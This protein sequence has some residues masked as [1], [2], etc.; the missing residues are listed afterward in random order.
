LLPMDVGVVPQ[1]FSL[2]S[3]GRGFA[4]VLE[5][6][7]PFAAADLDPQSLS[8]ALGSGPE[9]PVDP[10]SATLEDED[11][12]GVEELVVHLDRRLLLSEVSGF[13]DFSIVV[14]GA[15]RSGTQARGTA[16]LR[17]LA[18]PAR[19]QAQEPTP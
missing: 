10:F 8:A 3:R 11:G 2:R 14:Q 6:R 13:G 7:T 18:P 16:T 1:A 12:D 19:G 15:F 5:P 9:V 4:L 17:L